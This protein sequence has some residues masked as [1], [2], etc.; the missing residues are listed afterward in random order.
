MWFNELQVI[1]C[2]AWVGFSL[3]N[4]SIKI[5]IMLT[6]F[7]LKFH[8]AVGNI[9]RIIFAMSYGEISGQKTLR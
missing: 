9:K 4:S 2:A 5:E 1:K 7:N 8:H 3:N 6:S